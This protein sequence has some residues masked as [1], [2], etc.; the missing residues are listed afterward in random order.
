MVS[1][2][3]ASGFDAILQGLSEAG[4]L[5]AYGWLIAII[6]IASLVLTAFDR[7]FDPDFPKR[8]RDG[9]AESFFA[10]MSVATSGRTPA[11]KNLFGWL[12]RIWSALWL[13]CGIAVL[14]YV[15][16]SVTSVMTTLAITGAID[17]PA[18]LPG[19]P[20]GVFAGSVAEEF[21]KTSVLNSRPFDGIEAAVAAL[22]AGNIDA[23]VGDA[24]DRKSVV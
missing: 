8:W 1:E 23:I 10:V 19:R 4:H 21:S 2:Q 24:P 3:R 11:R 22:N 16:S 9:I 17:G 12:G 15:T 5:R 7:R 18:D 20:I 14:A 13:V 6:V